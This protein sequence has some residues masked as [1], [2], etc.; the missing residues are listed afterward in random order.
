MIRDGLAG[1]R[2]SLLAEF[3]ALALHACWRNSAP[4]RCIS[5]EPVGSCWQ[6]TLVNFIDPAGSVGR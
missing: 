4:S 1:E 3:G 2:D 6:S 5:Q